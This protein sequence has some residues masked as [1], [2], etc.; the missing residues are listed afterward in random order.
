M[1]GKTNPSYK[2]GLTKH[3][4][5]TVWLNMK[6]RCL[7]QKNIAFKNYGNRGITVSKRWATNFLTFYYW[8]LKNGW[9]HG[10]TIDRANNNKGYSPSNCRFVN[11]I[12][13]GR[14]QRTRKTN[15]ISRGVDIHNGSF[16]VRITVNKKTIFLGRFN[17]KKKAVLARDE[18]IRA[19]KL[20]YFNS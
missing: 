14:N 3:P 7:Y 4:L 8:S 16:R 5:Y 10:L 20:K 11:R 1:P 13:Q 2:H 19:N 15:K 12:I 6:S 9:K 17:S 18:Y